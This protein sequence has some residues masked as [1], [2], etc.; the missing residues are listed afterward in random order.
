MA[1]DVPAD[2]LDPA[3]SHARQ[4]GCFELFAVRIVPGKLREVRACYHEI[5]ASVARAS[6]VTMALMATL[7]WATRAG[8]ADAVKQASPEPTWVAACEAKLNAA[9]TALAPQDQR[10]VNAKVTRSLAIPDDDMFKCPPAKSSDE[11]EVAVS[12]PGYAGMF[13]SVVVGDALASRG[14]TGIWAEQVTHDTGMPGSNPPVPPGR[15]SVSWSRSSPGQRGNVSI[16]KTDGSPATARFIT[17]MKQAVDACLASA[18]TFVLL[19]LPG[20]DPSWTK[21]C[22][23]RTSQRSGSA[24][25]G[26]ID[27]ERAI[28]DIEAMCGYQSAAVGYAGHLGNTYAALQRILALGASATPYL[29]RLAHS[30]NPVARLAAIDGFRKSPGAVATQELTRLTSDRADAPSLFGCIGGRTKVGD[31]ARGVLR[32]PVHDAPVPE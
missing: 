12:F 2:A 31:M 3:R 27:A 18:P 32:G 21:V 6:S 30:Q 8:A 1:E 24:V 11:V 17:E 28:R 4:S 14:S 13:A 7:S 5:V 15:D 23:Q 19:P 10:L 16:L 29:V 9:I 25:L 22:Q 20:D 26:C